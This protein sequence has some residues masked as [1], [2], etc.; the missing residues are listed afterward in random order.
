M[1]EF[2]FA[3]LLDFEDVTSRGERKAVLTVVHKLKDLGGSL[4]SPH[5]KSLKGETDLFE[6]RPRQ[7]NSAVRPVY[8]RIS[9]RFVILAI[10][11]DKPS[12]ERAVRN[13]RDRLAQCG[14]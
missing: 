2:D 5:M 3:A 6:L 11:K 12:F 8:A 1:V 13:A 4:P 7:G 10:A 14:A 9:T